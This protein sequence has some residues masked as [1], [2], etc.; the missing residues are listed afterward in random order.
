MTHR[1]EIEGVLQ[2]TVTKSIVLDDGEMGR[3][4]E[5]LDSGAPDES[6]SR[7]LEEIAIRENLASLDNARLVSELGEVRIKD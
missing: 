5:L 2:V 7:F 3:Y 4:N 6:V 1:V